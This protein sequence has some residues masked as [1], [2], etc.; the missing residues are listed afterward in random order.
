MVT[1][2]GLSLKRTVPFLLVGILIFVAYLH[3]FV[4]IPKM[5][6]IIQSVNLFYYALAVAVLFL[7]MLATSLAWQYFLRPLSIKVSLRKTFLFTWIGV[8]VDLLVPAE[9]ISGDASKAYLM[10]KGSGENAGKVVASVVS[11]RIL[12]MII[13]LGSLI[14]SSLTLY[15]LQYELPAFVLNIIL[16]I[17]IG[18][19]IA[20]F[21]FFLFILKESLTKRLIDPLL[22]FLAFISRGRLELSSLRDKATKTLRAFHDSIGILLRNPK[23]LVPPVF[24]SIMAWF[25]SVLLSYLVFVSLGQPVDFVLIMIVHSISVSV[26]SVPFGIPAEVGFVEIVMTTLYGL[27]GVADIVGAAATVLIRFL[28]VG[29]RILIGFVMVQFVGIKNLTE[30]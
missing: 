5:V 24:F 20:L 23:S 11:H 21:F 6:T 19:V 17:I 28:W 10:T 16:F 8:F 7:N 9:S 27:L 30:D 14:F 1:I 3:F 25:F 2:K 22:R 12:A 29:L 4:G 13:T 18:T 15:I 26:Q